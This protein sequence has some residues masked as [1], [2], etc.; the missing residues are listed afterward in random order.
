L[1]DVSRIDGQIR[2]IPILRISFGSSQF[3]TGSLSF[4]SLFDGV[5]MRTRE[6]GVNKFTCVWVTRMDGQI[7]AL[8]HSIYNGLYV[9]EIQARMDALGVEIQSQV[10]EVDIS[11]AFS[12]AEKTTLNSIP[13]S[14]EAKFGRRN[15]S[16]LMKPDKL[17]TA[18][19]G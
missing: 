6:G 11:G 17:W 18:K 7:I 2:D 3:M 12:I 16:T 10:Y 9:I 13:A 15:S 5:L 4:E 14:E 1:P 8:C 19:G